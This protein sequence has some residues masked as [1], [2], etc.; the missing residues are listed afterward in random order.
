MKFTRK[1]PPIFRGHFWRLV[2][3]ASVALFVTTA[4]FGMSNNIVMVSDVEIELREAD[5]ESKSHNGS[6][7]A[8]TNLFVLFVLVGLLANLLRKSR[9]SFNFIFAH[10]SAP[11]VN[12]ANSC[13][14]P[15][16]L[17]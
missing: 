12:A 10:S 15:P 5:S 11:L 7:A 13:R 2:V 16:I 6:A 4:S 3:I 1:Y 17:H 8:A 9:P 14:A